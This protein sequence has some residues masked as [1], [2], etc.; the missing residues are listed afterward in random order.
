[1]FCASRTKARGRPLRRA[2][3]GRRGKRGDGCVPAPES[4]TQPPSLGGSKRSRLFPRSPSGAARWALYPFSRAF[5]H[6]RSRLRIY[7]EYTRARVPKQ[8][9]IRRDAAKLASKYPGSTR[10]QIRTATGGKCLADN[11]GKLVQDD[12]MSDA[13]PWRAVA[14]GATMRLEN[15]DTGRCATPSA[16]GGGSSITVAFTGTPGLPTDWV[17]LSPNG[18]PDHGY[19]AYQH[20]AGATSARPGAPCSLPAHHGGRGV[21][22]E[23]NSLLRSRGCRAFQRCCVGRISVWNSAP[24]PMSSIHTFGCARSLRRCSRPRGLSSEIVPLR[25]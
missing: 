24:L 12:C 23:R 9:G 16:G 13:I 6:S 11:G 5:A 1:V 7:A 15:T 19:V 17:S 2:Q 14:S 3:P 22:A 25:S 20:M 4:R 18:S 8:S 10:V 21:K